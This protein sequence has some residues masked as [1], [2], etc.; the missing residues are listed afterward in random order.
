[1]RT[2]LTALLVSL[3]ISEP[4]S[5][6]I[7]TPVEPYSVTV[8]AT[9]LDT[10]WDLAWGPDGMIW[11]SERGGRITRMDPATG[12][13]TVAGSI[14]VSQQGEGGLMGI[15]FHPDF[16]REPFV[17]AM[18][19][20]SSMLRAHNRLV[21]MRW[22]ARTLGAPETLLEGSPGAG[23]HNGS[24]IAVGPD[25]MLYV[26]TGDA[27]SGEVAQDR[28]SLGG[29]ILRLT[30]DGRPAPGNPFGNAAWSFGH[31]N[32]QGLVFHPTTGVLYETEHG[33][34]DNDEV[35]I[36]RRGGNYGWPDVHGMCDDDIGPERDFCRRNSVIEP[37]AIWTP[38]IAITGA[39]FYLS[40]R[41]PAWRGSLLATS[42]KA[43]TLYRFTLS[44]DGTRIVGREPL[45]AGRFGRLR[46][47]LVAPNGDV[48]I[49][50]SNRDGRGSPR[51]DDDRIIRISPR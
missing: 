11:F 24:R 17:Y 47:V 29:K 2:I 45:F 22:N 31:R 4:G 1:M 19:T 41:I 23:I 3:S 13:R 27:G 15:A 14:A 46:D 18:H 12:A 28:E 43:E 8:V 37:L 30:L 7:P 35:N 34:S 33:P 38:T 21:R 50:T 42:L 36:I 39:D 40:D 51:R 9:G 16:A 26:T 48:Y 44:P 20:Y 32:P 6:Q 10:P 25:R 5:S 49:A